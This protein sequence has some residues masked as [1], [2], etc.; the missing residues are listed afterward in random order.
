MSLNVRIPK[1]LHARLTDRAW[2]DRR[3]LNREILWLLETALETTDKP[4]DGDKRAEISE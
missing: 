2:Q 3:S 4:K 1:P